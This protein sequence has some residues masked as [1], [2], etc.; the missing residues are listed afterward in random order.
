MFRPNNALSCYA[1]ILR[2]PLEATRE[3]RP[4]KFGCQPY[5]SLITFLVLTQ[6]LKT[7]PLPINHLRDGAQMPIRQAGVGDKSRS[8][9]L[10]Q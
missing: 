8:S 10:W 1:H 2:E 7:L 6:H 4:T 9:G 3:P 5:Q